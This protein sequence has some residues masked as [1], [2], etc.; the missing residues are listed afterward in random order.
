MTSDYWQNL[1]S[2]L[3]S[4]GLDPLVADGVSLW[5]LAFAFRIVINLINSH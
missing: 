2:L 4:G 1:D 5:V 3:I